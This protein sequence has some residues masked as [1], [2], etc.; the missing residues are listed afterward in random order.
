MGKPIRFLAAKIISQPSFP[1]VD[2]F[3]TQKARH[4]VGKQFIQLS[5]LW[6]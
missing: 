5:I 1:A 2:L 6:I 4:S 3:S